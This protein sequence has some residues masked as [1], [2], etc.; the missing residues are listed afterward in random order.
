MFEFEELFSIAYKK[1]RALSRR[2]AKG[3]TLSAHD[4]LIKVLRK[5]AGARTLHELIDS[6]RLE[7]H[8][9]QTALQARAQQKIAARAARTKPHALP[10]TAAWHAWFDGSAHPNPGRIGI[11]GLLKG[12]H[13]EVVEISATAGRGDSCEAEYLALI[14]VLEAALEWRPKK[15]VIHGDSQVVIGDV[16]REEGAA[17]LTAYA[18]KARALIARLGDVHL[19]WI[20]RGRNTLA[21]NLS[22]RAIRAGANG[23]LQA[24]Q[25]NSRTSTTG[26]WPNE[27]LS[28]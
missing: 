11:G 4:A 14:A 21:D 16:H 5:S 1:E 17:S 13:G 20:P 9:A 28:A 15:L 3:A 26:V 2:L 27:S 8:K 25:D 10:D 7:Q 18:S 24:S 23:E 6:R 19:Q 22:Q 12:P